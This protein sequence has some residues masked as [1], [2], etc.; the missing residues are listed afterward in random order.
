MK[1]PQRNCAGQLP[2]LRLATVG[3]HECRPE[4][5]L[6]DSLLA[7]GGVAG[8]HR[9]PLEPTATAAALLLLKELAHFLQ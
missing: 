1:K 2:E 3:R 7:P 4:M 9:Q 8:I 6:Q 5:Q